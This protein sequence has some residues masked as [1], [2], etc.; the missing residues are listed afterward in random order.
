MGAGAV[1]KTEPGLESLGRNITG[2]FLI[3]AFLSSIHW[4]HSSVMQ[5][6]L[7]AEGANPCHMK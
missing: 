6:I 3:L 7:E 4:P 5:S 2:N 1:V